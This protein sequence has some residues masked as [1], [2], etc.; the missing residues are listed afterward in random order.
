MSYPY[1][2]YWAVLEDRH[3]KVEADKE[4]VVVCEY[5]GGFWLPCDSEEYSRDDFKL[6]SAKPLVPVFEPG[7][8][9]I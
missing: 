7:D 3:H 8:D 5:M 6:I 4:P 2:F 1:T 9:E